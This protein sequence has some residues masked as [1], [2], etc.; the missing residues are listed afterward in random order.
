MKKNALILITGASGGVGA[1]VTEFLLQSGWRNLAC[2]YR[3]NPDP[4]SAVLAKYN[5]DPCERL[6]QA[7]L[8]D[9]NEVA[10]LHQSVLNRFGPVYGL[11]N[12][13]GGSRNGMS[14]K[15]SRQEFQQ[16]MDI[17]LTTTFLTCREFI[18]EMRG[19]AVGR[20][21]NISSVVAY[22]G[23]AGAAHYC[24]AKAA[25]IGYSKSLALELAPKNIA[26]A[27]IVLGYFDF[28][29]IHTI[30]AEQRDQ[31][32][33]R[34]PAQEFGQAEHIGGLL[35]FLLSDAGAYSSGQ[36]YHLNGGL[37]S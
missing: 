5:L 35:S 9:E 31:I 37:Y 14:W 23:V 18:P 21:V 10:S 22:T 34:I 15:M 20:I 1:N 13:A 7:D 4:I 8:T 17:N 11:V 19:Q 29:L 16:I 3:S 32:R 27:V 12:L 30:P 28:G 6:L 26:T 24:A 2:Q 33:K 25:I 36:V